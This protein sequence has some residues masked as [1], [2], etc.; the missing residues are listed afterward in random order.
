LKLGEGA[1]DHFRVADLVK[2]VDIL[3]LRV[4]IVLAVG[5][6]YTGDLCKVFI[7]GTISIL[8]VSNVDD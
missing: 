6:V 3:E 4:G 7:L 8:V 2:G 1:V 5:M